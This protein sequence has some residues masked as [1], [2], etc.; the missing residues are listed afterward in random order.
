MNVSLIPAHLGF[1]GQQAVKLI[2]AVVII[3]KCKITLT[4]L[5]A[6]MRT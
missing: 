4:N 5:S 1:P 3:M 2:V 6:V